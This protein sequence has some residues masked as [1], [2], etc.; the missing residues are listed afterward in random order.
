MAIGQQRK[1]VCSGGASNK[2][3]TTK[4]GGVAAVAEER[5]SASVVGCGKS[6]CDKENRVKCL[7]VQVCLQFL[8]SI[9]AGAGVIIA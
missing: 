1:A 6:R 7:S 3:K 9:F 5:E 4:S 8:R 2:N